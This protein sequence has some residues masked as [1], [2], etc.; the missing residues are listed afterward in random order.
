MKKMPFLKNFWDG[1]SLVIP[2]LPRYDNAIY[3]TSPPIAPNED[4][5]LVVDHMSPSTSMKVDLS[6][7]ICNEHKEENVKD[8]TA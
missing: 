8:R 2:L 1:S 6:T 3:A 7:E 5:N 4:L